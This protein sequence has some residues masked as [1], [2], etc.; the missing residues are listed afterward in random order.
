MKFKRLVVLIFA[1]ILCLFVVGCENAKDNH[2]GKVKIV[3]ELE[4]GEYQNTKKPVVHYYNLKKDQEETKILDW[5]QDYNYII[6]AVNDKAKTVEDV[7]EL[8]FL[9]WWTFL[10]YFSERSPKCQIS[11]I[12]SLR[13]KIAKG[14]KL[15]KWEQQL[16]KSNEQDIKFA[17]TRDEDLE[18]T[19]WG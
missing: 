10:G 16:L 1:A 5:E 14:E 15:D 4:G 7:R 8:P 13:D 2:E 18:K 9:H 12:M 11:T 17:S 6:S 19:L 3:F